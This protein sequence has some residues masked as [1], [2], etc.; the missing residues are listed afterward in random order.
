MNKKR[1]YKEF[2]VKHQP[3]R[4]VI[5][6]TTKLEDSNHYQITKDTIG[7]YTAHNVV[8]DCYYVVNAKQ[9]TCCSPVYAKWGLYKHVLYILQK[10]NLS[11]TIIVCEQKFANC[12]N[13]KKA[14]LGRVH[15]AS[16]AMN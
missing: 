8:K 11:S 16:S 9:S 5:C 10:K 7:D 3:N 15:H 1:G 4:E 2:K 14:K 13:T 6:R 12:G